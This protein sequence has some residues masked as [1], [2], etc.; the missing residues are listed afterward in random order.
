MM[1]QIQVVHYAY[2]M[3]TF[4]N[5]QSHK[6]AHLNL[7]ILESCN[8]TENINVIRTTSKCSVFTMQLHIRRK[9]ILL[10]QLCEYH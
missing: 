4:G 5:R 9:N 3:F 6:N 7:G 2:C 1:W 8:N 10:L